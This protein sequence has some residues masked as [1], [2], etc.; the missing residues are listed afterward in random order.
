[1]QA[2]SP[3]AAPSFSKAEYVRRVIAGEGFIPG[4]ARGGSEKET[5]FLAKL[6][7]RKDELLAARAPVR[8]PALLTAAEFRR[9]RRNIEQSAWGR[10]WLAQ[11]RK[12]ADHVAGQAPG[13]VQQ[14]I[15]ELTPYPW[16]FAC[17]ACEG[18]KSQPGMAGP[19][20]WDYR[21]PETIRCQVC[22]Q[23][24]PDPAFPESGILV[25]PRMGQTFTCFLTMAE[26]AHPE[27][28]SGRHARQAM[29]HPISAS[30]AGRLRAQKITFMIQ[31]A[32]D[33]ALMFGLT[34]EPRY[35]AG[36]VEILNRFA[37]CHRRWLWHDQYNTIADCAPA[38]AAWQHTALN[39]E[40]KRHFA[41]QAFQ[42]DTVERAA[43]LDSYWGAGRFYPTTGGI[44]LVLPSLL[45]AYDLTHAAR[46]ASGA[47]L[48]DRAQREAVER[49]FLDFALDGEPWL[50]GPGKLSNQAPRVF[51]A[52]G[53]LGKCLGLPAYVDLALANYEGIR[54]QSFCPDGFTRESPNYTAMYLAGLFPLIDALDGFRWLEGYPGRTGTVDYF[55]TDPFL[56]LALQ[57]LLDALQPDGCFLPLGDTANEAV[58]WEDENK[59]RI[60]EI[61]LRRRPELVKGKMPALYRGTAPSE[62]AL[63]HLS[64]EDLEEDRGFAPPEILF[65]VWKTAILRHG[66]G[67][68]A[69]TLA[70]AFNPAGGHRHNDAL[71]LYYVNCGQKILGDLGYLGTKPQAAWLHRAACHNLVLVD[72]AEQLGHGLGGRRAPSLRLMAT[73]PGVSV[74]EASLKAYEQCSEYRRLVALFKG[75]GAA[76]LA[77]DIFRVRGGRK[78]DYRLFSEIAASDAPAARLDFSIA[79]MPPEPVLPDYGASLRPEHILGLQEARSVTHPPPHWQATWREKGA[80]YRLWLLTPVDRVAESHGPAQERVG[81]QLGRRAR[82]AHATREGRELASAFVA[83]HEPRGPAG[84][85]PIRKAERLAVPASA[86]P[87]AL[88]LRLETNWGDYLVFSEFERETEIAGVLCR[89]KFGVICDTPAGGNWRLI[90]GEA[91]WA[92]GIVSNTETTLVTAA[93]RP[94][95]WPETAEG[96]TVWARV[97]AE[98]DYTGYPVRRTAKNRITVGRFPLQPAARFSL[99]SVRY[100]FSAGR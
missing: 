28:R 61:G 84:S 95:G 49:L 99:P 6:E 79:R 82:Y 57:G 71:G 3:S 88:A 48:W 24:Y 45:L 29:G 76:S 92:G 2:P 78:H 46:A 72:D 7:A 51:A 85:F 94:A 62:Y 33:L 18:V 89:G 15:A 31:A 20:A 11:T 1:M 73:A 16:S 67:P 4:Q 55:Q 74:V 63:F 54:D 96:V 22:G 56:T 19:C 13:Y 39:L 17:P 12:I 53:M 37:H 52:V 43:M 93:P 5:T 100:E 9:A 26:R 34:G 98:D 65:P 69:T 42:A 36:A 47:P 23:A 41:G 70:L 97:G 58:P 40:W 86:G 10:K 87:A 66:V 38:Y 21:D 83:V 68:R 91:E 64:V 59:L 75:P 44:H 32:K 60:A 81:A 77:L 50:A 27:D 25:C 14:M 80:A 8:H 90:C 35:A 30:N